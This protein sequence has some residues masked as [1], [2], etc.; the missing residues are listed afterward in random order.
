MKKT[1][2]YEMKNLYRDDMRVTGYEFGEGEKSVC[3]VGSTRG[4]EIQ[5]LYTCGLLVKTLKRIEKAGM[6]NSAKALWLSP[7]STHLQ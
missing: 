3:V 6:I 1:V 7:Q 5:Q 2:L 4:N